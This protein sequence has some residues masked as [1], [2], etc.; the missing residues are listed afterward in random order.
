MNC[1][2]IITATFLLLLLLF[3]F[4]CSCNLCPIHCFSSLLYTP[5]PFLLFFLPVS[6]LLI[7]FSFWSTFSS[8]FS[9]S[10]SF[11]S[12]P[13]CLIL[14]F[15]LS[16]AVCCPLF[17]CLVLSFPLF[18]LFQFLWSYPLPLFSHPLFLS[19]FLVPSSIFSSF[20]LTNQ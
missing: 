3:L 6:S 9:S 7:L 5:L 11:D 10:L 17:L 20:T 16:P 2:L 12:L 14:S 8:A 4:P 1:K 13:I 15:S 18:S 19:L